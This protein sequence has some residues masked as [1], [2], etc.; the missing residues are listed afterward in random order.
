MSAELIERL[1]DEP[2]MDGGNGPLI[3]LWLADRDAIVS[4]LRQAAD[5]IERLSQMRDDRLSQVQERCATAQKHIALAIR[6]I[7]LSGET[8]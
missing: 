6:A 4:A 2:V 8:E 7:N 3:E 5:T 1:L